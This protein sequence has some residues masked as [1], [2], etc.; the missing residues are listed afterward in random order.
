MTEVGGSTYLEFLIYFVA[1]SRGLCLVYAA[2]WLEV[3]VGC[4][5]GH[6]DA[7]RMR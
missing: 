6:D 7:R 2:H 1:Y 4:C 5:D 3:A